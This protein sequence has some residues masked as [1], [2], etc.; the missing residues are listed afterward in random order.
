MP[1]DLLHALRIVVKVIGS[2][3]TRTNDT[4]V[5]LQDVEQLRQLVEFCLAQETAH[6]QHPSVVLGSDRSRA[7]IG[8][9][10]KHRSELQQT[11]PAPPVT[12]PLLPIKNLSL[13]TQPQYDYER[14]EQRQ[15]DKQRRGAEHDV[16]RALCTA[17][18]GKRGVQNGETAKAKAERRKS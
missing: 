18:D 3:R 2:K 12:H 15:Q 1:N 6:G 16:E 14:N 5:A 4:H 17:V 7:D 10:L 13:A 8:A 9:V 11:E